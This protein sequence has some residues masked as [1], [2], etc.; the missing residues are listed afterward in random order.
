[1]NKRFKLL[2]LFAA[3]FCFCQFGCAQS[4]KTIHQT[5]ALDGAEKVVVNIIG[6]NVEMREIPEMEGS[7]ILCEITVK[8][9]VDND[10]FLNFVCNS[11]RYE[12]EKT[13]DAA[14]GELTLASKKNN[15]VMMIKGEECYEELHYVFY[16]PAS[17][18]FRKY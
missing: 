18:K 9:S 16:V 12:L 2:S 7:L 6:S 3:L 4:S 8:L 17:V 10:K 5:L 1:M 14:T 11:G 15:N 13:L